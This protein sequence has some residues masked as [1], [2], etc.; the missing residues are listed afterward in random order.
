MFSLTSLLNLTPLGAHRWN[1]EVHCQNF[2]GKLYGGQLLGQALIAV[3]NEHPLRPI[4]TL[5]TQ[6]LAASDKQ[7]AI[8]YRVKRLRHGRSFSQYQIS[9]WQKK[10][11]IAQMLA[12]CHQGETGFTH[13]EPC[14]QA[15][16]PQPTTQRQLAPEINLWLEAQEDA[17]LE[18][19]HCEG[20]RLDQSTPSDGG[21]LYWL[22]IR[23]TL[24]PQ[25]QLPALAF[26]SDLGILA[27]SLIPHASHL[28]HPELTPASLNHTIWFHQPSVDLN[29]WHLVKTH[30]PWAGAGRGLGHSYV[31]DQKGILIASAV[32]EGLIRPGVPR[33]NQ[34]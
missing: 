25:Q 3:N 22:R 2:R 19:I 30:S 23:P 33:A 32:Q 34:A 5:H 24:H 21:S 7:A 27:S 15:P 14:P 29:Q 11:L 26:I 16:P 4:H 17:A 18:L 31:F 1:S 28:F 6:F 13:Q 10:R 12:A 20:A 9:A 8:E